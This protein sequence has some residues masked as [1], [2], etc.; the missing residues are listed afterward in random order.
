MDSCG[1]VRSFPSSLLPRASTDISEY[2][3][4]TVSNSMLSTGI[5]VQLNT[6]IFDKTLRRKDISAPSTSSP[7]SP[8]SNDSNDA[9]EGD[10]DEEEEAKEGT[11]GFKTKSSLTNLFAIDSERCVG[12]ASSLDSLSEVEDA[13][14]EVVYRDV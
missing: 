2:V 1:L 5:R 8:N 4:E 13:A 10:D 12:L 3:R 14:D 7:S 9:D 6:L 11:G